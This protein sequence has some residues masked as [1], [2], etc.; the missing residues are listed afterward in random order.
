MPDASAGRISV[1]KSTVKGFQG[2]KQ[3]RYSQEVTEPGRQKLYEHLNSAQTLKVYPRITKFAGQL[4]F[5]GQ[6]QPQ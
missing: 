1:H 4:G 6:K 3:A 5:D 2:L